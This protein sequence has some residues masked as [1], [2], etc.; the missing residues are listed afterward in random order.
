MSHVLT[1][2][3]E[4]HVIPL[5]L[6]IVDYAVGGEAVALSELGPRGV[7]GV[8]GVMLAPCPPS[9]NALAA[10]LFPI[11]DAGRVKLFRFVSGAPVEIPATA[12]LN[13]TLFGFVHITA[14]AA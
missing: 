3:P 12:G 4:S 2:L 1:Q 9:Q 7:F 10:V 14:F 6:L 11:L 5:T 8:S 13:A